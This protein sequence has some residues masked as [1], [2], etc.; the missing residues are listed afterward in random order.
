MSSQAKTLLESLLWGVTV[1]LISLPADLAAQAGVGQPPRTL[2]MWM[3]E[4]RTSPFHGLKGSGTPE[5][6]A[7]VLAVDDRVAVPDTVWPPVTQ[8]SVKAV[9]P[10][11]VLGYTLVGSTIPGMIL[12]G[13][14]LW[15]GRMELGYN[16]M[17]AMVY[18]TVATLATVPA[19]AMIA[20]TGSLSRT[21]IS[22][23]VGLVAGVAVGGLFGRALPDG[24]FWMGPIY[25]VTMASV[26]TAIAAR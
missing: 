3:E 16:A 11:R 5:H 7:V 21:R 8:A 23:V 9:S 22:T 18:G 24:E 12:S 10:G 6:P 25:A 14:A 15:G 26:T 1:A 19:A 13:I 17:K 4:A 2:G 20:G